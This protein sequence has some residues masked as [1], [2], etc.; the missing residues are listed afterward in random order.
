MSLPAILPAIPATKTAP[1]IAKVAQIGL[2]G[3]GLNRVALAT[4]TMAVVKANKH[5]RTIPKYKSSSLGRTTRYIQQLVCL[6][7]AKQV[8][9]T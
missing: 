7:K 6:S 8:G 3:V 9:A 1:N 2:I 4:K 5:N